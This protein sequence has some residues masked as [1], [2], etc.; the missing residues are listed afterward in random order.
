MFFRIGTCLLLLTFL[1]ASFIGCGNEEEDVAKSVISSRSYKGHENDKDSNNICQAYPKIVGTRLD[2]CQTCHVGKMDT[3]KNEQTTNACDYC[4]ELMVQGAGGG[5]TFADT[6]NSF[7][8]DY[9]KNGRTLEAINK[10]KTLDS[11]GDSYTNDQE[12]NEL[13]YPGSNLSKLGQ[14]NAPTITVSMDK[15]KSLPSSEQFLLSNTSKQQFD[16]YATYKGV[17]VK[18]LLSSL[19][20]DISGATGVSFIAPDGFVKTIMTAQ[21]TKTFPQG[22]FYSGLDIKTLGQECGFVNYPESMPAGLTNTGKIPGDP[23]LMIAYGRDGKDMD[24]CYLDS[25]QL[26]LNGEGPFRLVVPQSTPGSPDRGQGFSPSKC[27]DGFDYDSKKDHNAGSMVRG[28]MA[29]RVD[30]MPKGVEEFDYKNGGWA[31][32]NSKEILIYG[33]N[34][35]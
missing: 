5:K 4:H 29:I 35:K 13:K 9:L 17:S 28:V 12:I 31:Y 33:Y 1:L 11:D 34:V 7:G 23:W 3:V 10:I 15:I 21:V 6:L 14:P 16:D 26:K 25:V 22:L 24:P 2:D 18:N 20:V 8:A 30:P 27:N 32:I 19:G